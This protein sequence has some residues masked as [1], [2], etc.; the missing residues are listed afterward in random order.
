MVSSPLAGTSSAIDPLRG[1][2]DYWGP[3]V[4]RALRVGIISRGST[5]VESLG[6]AITPTIGN[7]ILRQKLA[8]Q[9]DSHF[10]EDLAVT[11]PCT[12]MVDAG[13]KDRG[14]REHIARSLVWIP[15]PVTGHVRGCSGFTFHSGGSLAHPPSFLLFGPKLAL[16]IMPEG[17]FGSRVRSAR[18]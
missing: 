15:A 6:L 4:R 1:S 10:E 18:T 5:D 3:F 12:A 8:P 2:Q 7:G 14:G 16:A 9:R 17:V 13:G 11:E